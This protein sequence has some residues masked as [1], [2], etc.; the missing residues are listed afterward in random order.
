[1]RWFLIAVLALCLNGCESKVSTQ[2]P[3]SSVNQES[4]MAPQA[5]FKFGSTGELFLQDNGRENV[6]VKREPAGINFYKMRWTTD[7]YGAVKIE[8][9]MHGFKVDNVLSLSGT[10]DTETLQDGFLFFNISAVITPTDTISHLE[11]RD[12]MMRML[13]TLQQ[14]GWRRYIYRAE[15]RVKSR[16]S[17][18]HAYADNLNG[19]DLNYVPT[20]QEWMRLGEKANWYLYADGAYLTMQ[21]M[22]DET[23]MHPDQPGAYLLTFEL[24]TEAED[25]KGYFAPDDKKRWKELWPARNSALQQERAAAEVKARAQGLEIDTTYQDPPILALQVARLT[26]KVGQPAPKAGWW[27]ASS[28]TNNTRIWNLEALERTVPERLKLGEPLSS[29]SPSMMNPKTIAA[30]DA[31]TVWTWI[32]E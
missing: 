8:H 23:R 21:F 12:A 32:K 27:K 26:A 15:P 24:K 1:M 31:D 19:L 3:I 4:Y 11:A 16:S 22:R 25:T 30:Q 20:L 28:A 14:A 6:L 17:L 29:L 10:E 5:T 13:R 9:G 18:L 2:T 7:R